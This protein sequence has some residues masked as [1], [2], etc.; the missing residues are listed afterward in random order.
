M[1]PENVMMSLSEKTPSKICMIVM[2]GLGGIPVKGQT[3][4]EA[5][6]CPNLD[7]FAKESACGR[8][9]PVAL[10]ITP[11]SGPGHLALFG[12]NPMTYQIG[13]GVLEALGIGLEMN[14]FDMAARA[15]FATLK[16]G[17]IVDRRAGRIPT[18]ENERLV[19]KLSEKITEIDD[20]KV[21]I[22]PGK[23]HRFVVM[24][25]GENL[26][27]DL[28][29]ADPQ[30]EGLAPLE[31]R[32]K[33]ESA[34]RSARIVNAFITQLNEV[35]NDEPVANTALMRGFACLPDIPTMSELYKLKCGAFAT[36]PMYKGLASLVGMNIVDCGA[37]PESQLASLKK[38]GGDY[39]FVFYHYKYTDSRG[40][41]SDFEGKVKAIEDFDKLIPEII[42]QNFDVVCI[43]ADHSTPAKMGNHSWHPSPIAIR[44][45]YE[46]TDDVS[47]F[48]ERAFEN[49]TLG[50]IWSADIMPILMANALK[51]KKFGA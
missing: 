40:E 35:L 41:D 23:E 46:M 6:A 22:Y 26:S 8:N 30:K 36:Y 17:L 13:R 2:D 50:R 45:K 43:T 19:K 5:A 29:D 15:N 42:S 51:L 11:G 31:C 49:G 4:L 28:A 39:D 33:S 16:D 10:G 48:S 9:V 34:S 25:T 7:A 3:E 12:Y 32:N 47:V 44:S 14:E 37:T 21:K 18:E 38:N 1:F 20:V 27:G 24:F